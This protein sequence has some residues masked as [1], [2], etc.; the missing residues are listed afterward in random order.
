MNCVYVSEIFR[1]VGMKTE[2]YTQFECGDITELFT[3]DKKT[4]R[5]TKKI[6]DDV[7][8]THVSW[9]PYIDKSWKKN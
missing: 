2:I 1:Y 5:K 9:H 4:L 7:P 3:K 8:Y 6:L